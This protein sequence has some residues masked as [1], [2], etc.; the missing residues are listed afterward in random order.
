MKSVN[1]SSKRVC[2][3]ELRECNIDARKRLL[4]YV[5]SHLF[6]QEVR[7]EK[8]ANAA[9]IKAIVATP[10]FTFLCVEQLTLTDTSPKKDKGVKIFM[11][12]SSTSSD[13]VKCA[14]LTLGKPVLAR[15]MQRTNFDR[16]RVGCKKKEY[17]K[18]LL[19]SNEETHTL[20]VALDKLVPAQQAKLA[21][22]QQKYEKLKGLK[23]PL[24]LADVMNFVISRTTRP[25]LSTIVVKKEKK[26]RN[27]ELLSS[28]NSNTAKQISCY[29]EDKLVLALRA[30]CVNFQRQFGRFKEMKYPL[31]LSVS[32]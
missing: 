21:N 1:E 17:Y 20:G 26:K 10:D 32:M 6:N 15:K 31:T 25:S 19:A 9:R 24:R 13:L 29:T 4:S 27:F 7:Q 28:M 3:Y 14:S 5:R 23:R 16:Q 2:I 18:A 12:Q 8:K 11:L 30:M 22:L